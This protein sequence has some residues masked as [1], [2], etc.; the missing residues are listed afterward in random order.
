MTYSRGEHPASRANLAPPFQPG[1]SGCPGGRKPGSW[2]A[3]DHLRFMQGDEYTAIRLMEIRDDA[4]QPQGKRAAAH[5]MLAMTDD[6]PAV[7][8][9]AFTA[10]ADRLEGKPTQ[11]T[12]IIDEGPPDVARVLADLRAEIVGGDRPVVQG[13]AE[14]VPVPPP[15]DAP[16]TPDV[17]KVPEPLPDP[18]ANPVAEPVAEPP[19]EVEVAAPDKARAIRT[20]GT[21]HQ[22][23][24]PAHKDDVLTPREP[25]RR[26]W[27]AGRVPL[28]EM[29]GEPPVPVAGACQDE[30]AR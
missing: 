22:S 19:V 27:P 7:A 16:T 8:R 25:D 30:G 18:P 13:S 23:W 12:R 10:V 17:V 2:T 11:S 5:L 1:E 14:P 4:N 21:S 28:S 29:T 3:A 9:L 26:A 6:D 24:R 15:V 20:T